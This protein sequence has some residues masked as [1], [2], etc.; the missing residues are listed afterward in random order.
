MALLVER[1]GALLS[2]ATG[3]REIRKGKL[4]EKVREV[5]VVFRGGRGEAQSSTAPLLCGV[6]HFAL[7][8]A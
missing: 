7:G 1:P 8:Q 6:A 5:G 3:N 2:S 4:Q